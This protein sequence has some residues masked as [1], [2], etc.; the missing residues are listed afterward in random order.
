MLIRHAILAAACAFAASATAGTVTQTNLVSDGTVSAAHTD[1]NLKNPWGISFGATGP[2]WVSDNATGLTTLYD[3]AGNTLGLVV[4]IPAATG[5]GT[6]SPTGQVFNGTA[7][8]ALG[9]GGKDGPAAFLFATEDGT[10]SGWNGQAAAVITVNQSR[11]NSVFKGLTIYTDTNKHNYL[12]VADFRLG[13]VEVFTGRFQLMSAFRDPSLSFNYAPYNVQVL[14]G[15]IYV[16]Y[17]KVDALRHDSVSGTGFG[18]VEKVDITGKILA[19]AYAGML[20]AP[21]GLAIAPASWGT[22]AGDLLVGNFGSGE[23]EAFNA[24][25][26][27]P[28]GLLNTTGGKPLVIDGLWGLIAGNGGSGGLSADVYFAAGINGEQDGLF[29]QLSYTP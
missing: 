29:G 11:I 7:S 5:K 12:L 18:V 26:L 15:A 24:T 27:A 16:T 25:T 2:F 1:P 13:L 8:F 6:G 19:H 10:I 9:A 14:N 23:I 4:P 22:L 28:Q 20:N 21:W 17:A 3:T